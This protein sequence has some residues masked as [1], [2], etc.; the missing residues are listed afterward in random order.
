MCDEILRATV[1]QISSLGLL[2]DLYTQ[3]HLIND[4]EEL[5]VTMF[6]KCD[7]YWQ[8]S[9]WILITMGEAPWVSIELYV[10]FS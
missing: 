9:G 2:M 1:E 3:L 5:T 8:T 10:I 4:K 7:N 6:S